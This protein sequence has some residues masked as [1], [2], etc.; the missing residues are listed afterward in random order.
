MN[1]KCDEH[2]EKRMLE[3]KKYTR[4]FL[5]NGVECSRWEG[6]VESK[7]STLR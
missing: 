7:K 1:G 2:D 5:R 3:R 6:V 4:K